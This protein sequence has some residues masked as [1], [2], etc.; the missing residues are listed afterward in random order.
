[1][2]IKTLLKIFFLT[3]ISCNVRAKKEAITQKTEVVTLAKTTKSWDK[4]LLPA[5]PKGQ[6]EITILKITIPPHTKLPMHKHPFINAGVLL[7]GNLTVTTKDG[8]KL[9]LKEGESIAEVVSTW[10]YGKNESDAPCEIIVFYAGI[11]GKPITIK[12]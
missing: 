6:P 1:M 2:K 9:H 11:K 3:I 7:K 5:Y 12:K 8:K 10:H 4:K